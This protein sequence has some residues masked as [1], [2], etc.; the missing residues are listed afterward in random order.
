[1]KQLKLLLV[2]CGLSIFA[3]SD[4]CDDV[5][6]GV[7]G[8]CVEGTCDCDEGYEG[9]FCET[10]TRAKFLGTYSGD[11]S[12]C[13]DDILG[14]MMLPGGIPDIS[15]EVTADANSVNNV[16]IGIDNELLEGEQ[17]SVN[18]TLGQFNLPSNTQTIEIEDIPFPLTIVTTGT[19]EFTDENTLV[20]DFVIVISLLQT[21]ECQIIMTK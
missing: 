17:I 3:C 6:C 10:E 20:I 9:T 2:F 7:N 4:P 8:T 5:D 18:P 12:P 21:I 19:G 11:I 14:G 13:F 15:L 1:M 16:V